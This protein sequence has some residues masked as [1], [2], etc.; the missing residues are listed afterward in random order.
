[1]VYIVTGITGTHRA[2]VLPYDTNESDAGAWGSCILKPSWATQIK[3][4]L[5]PLVCLSECSDVPT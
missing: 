5:L 3:L 4:T 2:K 1:M